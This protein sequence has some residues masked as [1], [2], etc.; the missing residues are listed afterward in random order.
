MAKPSKAPIRS[1]YRFVIECDYKDKLHF[2]GD[3]KH[4]FCNRTFISTQ[5]YALGTIIGEN[6]ANAVL[7]EIE[8][9]R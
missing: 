8:E 7:V 9:I 2:M 4:K 5:R 1:R 3:E 6:C